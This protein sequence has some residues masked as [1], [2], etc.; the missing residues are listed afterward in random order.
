MKQR[1]E[2]PL[3]LDL[4][5]SKVKIRS[6]LSKEQIKDLHEFNENPHKV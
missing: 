4:D 2:E 6:F 5:L 1:G 3:L